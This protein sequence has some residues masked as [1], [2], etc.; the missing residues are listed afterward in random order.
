[1]SDDFALI[2]LMTV[3]TQSVRAVNIW[4][5]S[6]SD[7]NQMGQNPVLYKIS[8]HFGSPSQK[9]QTSDISHI[10]FQ[11]GPFFVQI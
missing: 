2:T 11:S 8:E 9:V 1:M 6:G 3:K 5:Q 4:T 7:W 10:L